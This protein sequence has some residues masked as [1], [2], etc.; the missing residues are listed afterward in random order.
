[1]KPSTRLVRLLAEI[2]LIVA[3]AEAVIVL[4]LPR[5]LP[6]AG[7]GAVGLLID[8]VAVVILAAPL[9]FWRMAVAFER[10][11]PAHLQ[12]LVGGTGAGQSRSMALGIGLAA[13]VIGLALTAS[14]V[15]WQRSQ[16]HAIAEAEFQLQ[17]NRIEQDAQRRLTL[18]QYGLKGLRGTFAAIGGLNR[19][20]FK[21]YVESRDLVREFPGI[22]GMGFIER[23]PRSQIASFTQ[24]VRA[25]DS[26]AFHIQSSGTADDL[27]V[28][29]FIE[30]LSNN[31][32]AWGFDV[33]QEPIRRAGAER[34]IDT[35]EP[36]LTAKISLV[37]DANKT[38]GFLLFVP[39]YRNG[40][41]P[42]TPA[43][44]RAA[45]TGLVVAPIVAAE[46]FQGL[47]GLGRSDV[48]VDIHQ[49]ADAEDVQ[50]LYRV[51]LP[52][53]TRSPRRS[54]QHVAQRQ[55]EV[56]GTLITLR[57]R[58]TPQ[59][60]G[61]QD[62]STLVIAG[63]LGVGISFTIAFT[64]WL[65][66]VGRLRA[67]Q[68]AQSMTA[69]LDRMAR[70][71]Q[72]T[73]NAVAVYD[74]DSRVTWVNAGFTRLTGYSEAEALGKTPGEL[75]SSGKAD[76]G[77]LQALAASVANGTACRVE[78]LN[79]AKDGRE[80][81]VDTE[82][83]PI[84]NDHQTLV[85]FMEIGTDITTRVED[86]Q[87]IA[88]LSD[89]MALA[90]EGGSDGL[91]DWMDI[92][93]DAQWWSPSYFAMLGYAPH[94]LTPSISTHRALMHPECVALSRERLNIALAGG[95]AYD[96]EMQLQTKNAG[97]RWFRLR[98]KVF[99]DAQGRA[100]RMAGSTQD[101]H[102]RKLAQ[103]SVIKTNAR[104]ALAADSAGIGVWEWDLVTQALD[105]DVQMY[106]LFGR[107]PKAREP[108]R[109]ILLGSL[110]PQDRPRF[111]VDLQQTIR[112][113]K[114]FESTYRILWPN[115]EVRHLRAAA[116]VVRDSTGRALRLTGVNF[117]I[118]EVKRAQDA[119]AQSQ[120]FLE[121]AGRIAGVG[122]WRVDLKANAIYWSPETRRIHEVD[123]D[124]VPTLDGA[125]EFY[126]PEA[127]PV[128]AAAVKHGMETG[129]GWDLELPL[130]TAKGRAIWVRAVGEVEFDNGKP[131]MLV[132]AFQNIT[133]RQ[134]LAHAIRK[135]NQLMTDILQ[136]LPCGLSV[137]DSNLVLVAQNPQLRSLLGLPD[138][139]FSGPE[140]TF[141]QIIRYNAQAG[142]YGPGDVEAKV[143]ALIERARNPVVHAFERT[144]PNGISLDIRG[145]PLPGGGF[146]TTYVDIS[147]SKKAQTLLTQ[148]MQAAQQ[149]N[150][151]KSQF[152]ANMSHEIR[153]PMN[154]I[155][156]LLKLLQNTGLD[157][158]QHD[159]VAKT[160]GAARSL[161]GLL[162]DILDFSKV[163]A[164][165]MTLDQRP[166]RLDRLLRDLSVI[167][168]ASVG[169][170]D[171]E[172]LFDI[173]PD[174]PLVLVGDDMRL[175]QILINLGGNAIK[176]TAQGE[177]VLRWRR[178]AQTDDSVTV[179]IAVQDSGIG[180]A[181]QNQSLI[182]DGF[183]QA[184]ATT[185]RR[186]GGTGLGLAISSRLTTL[187][188]SELKLQS[189]LGVGSTF[190]FEVCFALATEERAAVAPPPVA[191]PGPE[192]WRT[193]MVDDNPIARELMLRMGRSLGWRADAADSGA[194]AVV[195]VQEAISR[196]QPYHAIFM[197]WQMPDMDGWQASQRIREFASEPPVI[198]M[199]T[200]HGREML[201][202]RSA[203]E[204]SLLNGFLVKP[205]T[206][207]M[208]LEALRD[209]QVG[210]AAAAAGHAPPSPPVL[211]IPKRLKG[212]RILVVE[213]NKIN[214]MVA[215][216]LLRA[217]G[218]LVSLA[219]DGQQGITAV[220]AAKPPF[221]VVLM[222]V[223]MPVMDGYTATR[224]MRN[225]MGLVHLPII[226][227]TAN[228]MASDRAECLEAGM[229]N[230]VGKPFELDQLV[231]II[232][233]HSAR[234][235]AQAYSQAASHPDA[236][237]PKPQ[238]DDFLPG[239]LDLEAA[240]QR[241]GGNAT[242]L[243]S[244]LRTFA[245]D[246]PKVPERLRAQWM[247]GAV[248]DAA[249][250]L[251]TLKGLASTVG[252]RHLAQVAARLEVQCK[253][254][255]GVGDFPALLVQL[256]FAV[257]ATV[258]NLIPV[259]QRSAQ[260]QAQTQGVRVELNAPTRSALRDA[261]RAL[262]SLLQESDMRAL[263]AY[264]ALR[265]TY[266]TA[267][268]ERWGPL[269]Q[270]MTDLEFATALACCD[271]LLVE[272]S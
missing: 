149:A 96:L 145:V 80:Y 55:M 53:D 171:V 258:Q 1:M 68:L 127:R 65:L 16:L 135:S 270:A 188:G 61:R 42:A 256:Q 202:Q 229:N 100:Y 112:H 95:T 165:K 40:T 185:T 172:V 67:Q 217:E 169:Q 39:I 86:A 200:A 130:V 255:A 85:G 47:T 246:L 231:A 245:D 238:E 183:A 195:R 99:F 210:M 36:T 244:I 177:V 220:A 52:A 186:F 82:I 97:Y 268:D 64:L 91:W 94:E 120:A 182:F 125:I 26:P 196:G 137:F 206:A 8:M 173:D 254:D 122:G 153:T 207:S 190:Y 156:G 168:S 233:Q 260:A 253:G 160:E 124:F 151:S 41:D 29:K 20:Q 132:G 174:L 28:I 57:M 44:R 266:G 2:L 235:G 34:A 247:Q 117:D 257:D 261:V 263:Q 139:L 119:L 224:V 93:Q 237:V 203:Q 3:A 214:Q 208:L 234:S 30:P 138:S 143:V 87:K 113:D 152:L 218:A 63:V 89:R 62:R 48:D 221:D 10:S 128:I 31:V 88:Q 194:E 193:L 211:V 180:I 54:A 105:W 78:I 192:A 163:E 187:M 243:S 50:L 189:A 13:L 131:V 227:M 222:D 76:A 242:M 58:S 144:R 134:L 49:G 59:F 56:A 38:P 107:D 141:E 178:V 116:R 111:E 147:E 201:A 251:H 176:F 25:D 197:D 215:L 6:S 72:Y 110:H 118:T 271:T 175:Q 109:E 158:R 129:Q 81:W 115:G 71:V 84:R 108:A 167:L 170:K 77:V 83:Q 154:A 46:L 166:F 191:L 21:A 51:V 225:A 126:A 241:L 136:H 162:N 240:T 75:L 66:A 184:E 248:Q 69:D 15:L 60:E 230:H 32:A 146:I 239:D 223:Q 249:R 9:I 4:L 161:L 140:T 252:A 264:A 213:D 17:A 142:E 205:V 70:V 204:Q 212:L 133:E 24:A 228:A 5:L 150:V 262:V 12:P 236:T 45:L 14:G 159:Y 155:L 272:L 98:A 18:P 74:A 267:M 181:V 179:Q 106:Q 23:V 37:Q 19:S 198:M 33:G 148:A 35:G 27:F 7:L 157:F 79:R 226:A 265:D 219:E 22:R 209:A 121:R 11:D 164:G 104:F 216:G 103:Q 123:D 73:N 90:I 199:V 101:V 259:L 114:A 43:Q 92:T 102:E 269:D 250:T 232:L